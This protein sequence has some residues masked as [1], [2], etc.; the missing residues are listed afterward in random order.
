MQQAVFNSLIENVTNPAERLRKRGLLWTGK[1]GVA[2]QRG[3]R[4]CRLCRAA[5]PSLSVSAPIKHS[6]RFQAGRGLR[7]AV[8]DVKNKKPGVTAA[9]SLPFARAG[10]T[11]VI[12]CRR[13]HASKLFPYF[14][15]PN[16][17][18]ASCFGTAVANIVAIARPQSS[19]VLC[20]I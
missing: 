17:Y 9:K 20:P 3:V 2:K 16:I 1:P 14:K 13:Y 18:S 6:A 7:A 15:I 19:R 12:I 4:L 8:Q 5:L 11:I 10:P